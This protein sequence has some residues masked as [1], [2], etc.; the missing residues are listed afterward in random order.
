VVEVPRQS[1]T[2]ET[3]KAFTDEEALTILSAALRAEA[4]PLGRRGW[5]WGAARRWVPWLCAYT[6]PR[7]GELTQLRAGDVEQRACGPVLRIT[8]EAGTVKTGNARWVPLHHHV[9]EMGFLDYVAAVEARLGKRGPLFYRPPPRPSRKPPAVRLRERLAEW[10]RGLGVT[11]PGIQPN[12]GWR[13]TFKTR[14]A[15]RSRRDRCASSLSAVQ[16]FL[17]SK[18]LSLCLQD[19]IGVFLESVTNRKASSHEKAVSQILR[20]LWS[21]S[22]STVQTAQ[23][24]TEAMASIS[25]PA[26]SI[27]GTTTPTEFHAAMQAENVSNGFLNCFL[28]LACRK[29][30]ADVDPQAD[31]FTVPARLGDALHQLYLWSGPESLLQINEPTAVFKPDVLPWASKQAKNTY[32]DLTRTVEQYSDD[33]PGKGDYLA[34][35]TETAIRLATILAA[36]RWGRGATVD[37]TDIEWGAGIAWTSGQALTAANRE[38]VPKTDRSNWAERIIAFIRDKAGTPKFASGVKPRD[39]QQHLKGAIKTLEIRDILQQAIDAG[40]IEKVPND[41]YRP[42]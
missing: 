32:L 17:Q 8:P 25:C 29:R 34:R 19:E 24:A 30:A 20:S 6:G 11:D 33:N 40:E 13:H 27:L 16:R 7:V 10:V 18:P 1:S 15:R 39:I 23:R 37:A 26:L 22:F 4:P 21:V 42:L 36:G 2:G 3:K 9:V 41:Y 14:A 28:V 35:T 38:F 31:P 12:Q 5:Q